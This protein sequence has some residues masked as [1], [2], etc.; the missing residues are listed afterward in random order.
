MDNDDNKNASDLPQILVTENLTPEDHREQQR[1]GA[2]RP[3]WVIIYNKILDYLEGGETV[4]EAFEAEGGILQ[5]FW[6][7]VTDNSVVDVE[8]RKLRRQ[9]L[10]PTYSCRENIVGPSC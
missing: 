6:Q 5:T 8:D 1:Q 7:Y 3:A 9:N 2:P 4:E 10:A